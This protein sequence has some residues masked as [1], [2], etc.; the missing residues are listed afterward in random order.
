MATHSL[1]RAWTAYKI[2]LHGNLI[3][4]LAAGEGSD[5]VGWSSG[6]VLPHAWTAWWKR[7]PNNIGY[8]N[9]PA[10][11]T[12]GHQGSDSSPVCITD[13]GVHL[14]PESPKGTSYPAPHNFSAFSSQMDWLSHSHTQVLSSPES[15]HSQACNPSAFAENLKEK[16]NLCRCHS[17]ATDDYLCHKG[18]SLPEN[19]AQKIKD[20]PQTGFQRLSETVWL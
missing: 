4:V 15:Q 9:N 8:E 14:L 1:S 18:V 7:T 12:A 10:E 2:P 20:G 5:V 19:T 13:R 3:F 11:K 17:R 16:T 6:A